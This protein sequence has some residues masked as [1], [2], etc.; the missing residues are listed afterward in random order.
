[1]SRPC[2]TNIEPDTSRVKR[3]HRPHNRNVNRLVAVDQSEYWPYTGWWFVL[4]AQALRLAGAEEL[5]NDMD[6]GSLVEMSRDESS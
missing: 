3:Q 2:H 4:F 5:G 1:M 6:P